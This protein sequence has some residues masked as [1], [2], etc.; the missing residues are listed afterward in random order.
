MFVCIFPRMENI[1]ALTAIGY[2]QSFHEPHYPDPGSFVDDTW[3]VEEKAKIVAYLKAAHQMPYAFGGNSWCRFRCGIVSLGNTEFTDGT[4]LWPEG[5]LHYVEKH[6]VKLPPA[7][8]HHMLS[9]KNIKPVNDKFSVNI[10]WWQSQT[11]PNTEVTTFNDRCDIGVLTIS[12]V[13]DK[14]KAKQQYILRVLLIND[15]GE[16]RS[17]LAIE[18]ILAGEEVQIKGE[19]DNVNNILLKLTPIGLRGSFRYI[20]KEEYE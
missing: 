17:L 15:I 9:N 13:N 12:Q 4:Y 5:L 1:T 16:K 7:V 8:L 6:N 3:N 19:F 18:K 2:W 20:T 14:M 10:E 11:G